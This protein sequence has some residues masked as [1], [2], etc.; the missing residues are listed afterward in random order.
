[1]SSL[2]PETAEV[3]IAGT[4]LYVPA[5]EICRRTVVVTGKW[6]RIAVVK[7]EEL[8]EGAIIED[9]ALFLSQLKHSELRADLF[10][11]AQKV[12][13]TTPKY[14]YYFEWDNWAAL[15]ITTAADWWKTLPQ[16]SRKNVRRAAKRGVV[17]RVT[18]FNDDLVKGIHAI[19]NET[20]IRQGRPFW[21]FGK[22][23]ETVK[24]ET[25]TYLDRSNFIGAYLNQELIGFV[26][27]V[28]VD[29]IASL[30]HIVSKTEHHEKRPTNA[31]LANTVELCE[32]KGM[33]FILYG[34]YV[35]GRH[36]KSLLTEFKRR[37]GFEEIR[38]P[39]YIVPLS[40]K[41]WLA[42]NTGLHAGLRDRLPAPLVSL[43]LKG[44]S[45]LYYLC[46]AR[47]NATNQIERPRDGS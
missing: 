30:M 31:L 37:N 35:Y 3:R 46:S 6:L 16:E 15:R 19:Y 36:R 38:V 17:V 34:K 14:G 44:R 41:G 39:R 8:V 7:D 21:H 27:V 42:I 18:E 47:S 20:P 13:D 45:R 40:R 12:S 26:K 33:S 9:P 32:S 43:L 1:M 28:Y 5:I 11:F 24:R 29:H 22:D 2:R 4:T 10:S 23:F 25:A